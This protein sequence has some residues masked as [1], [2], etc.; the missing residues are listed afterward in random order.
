MPAQ[1]QRELLRGLRSVNFAPGTDF[2]YC[3]GGYTLLTD[4]VAG[5]MRPLFLANERHSLS[6]RTAYRYYRLLHED[7]LDVALLSLAD[8]LATYDGRGDAAAWDALLDV[9]A[10]LLDVYFHQYERIV[11][12]PRLLD[13]RA[14]M[15]L[16]AIPPG[17]EIGRL[18]KLLEE[19]QAAGE[20]TT[21]DEAIAF[22]RQ[23]HA[24]GNQAEADQIGRRP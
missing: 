4:I 10:A 8:H 20:V 21:T 6:R 9:A 1:A 7:G 17:H 15:E 13:G 24:A 2:M 11:A 3:N 16:L 5:H 23:H 12:P 14:I 18:L 22:V 19:A